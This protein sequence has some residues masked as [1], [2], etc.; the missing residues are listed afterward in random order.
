MMYPLVRDLAAR[1]APIRVPVTVACR[2]LGF[3]KQGYY[4]WLSNPV[5]NRD[6]DEAHLINAAYD[7][8]AED[9][10]F[11]YRL[12]SDELAEQ[13]F[14]ASERRVWRLCSQQRLWSVFSK[15]KG[16]TRK[17]GPPVHDDLVKRVFIADGPN[18]LWL[19]DITEHKTAEGKLYLC[20]IKDVFANKIVG[21]SID[22]RMKARLAVD[23]LEMA[24]AHRGQPTGVVVH[25]DYAEDDVKPRN[26]AHASGSLGTA[27]VL[28]A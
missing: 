5:S 7:A 14:T 19:T 8:H 27:L 24:V 6:W 4:R 3:S 1:S 21:Y 12:I 16:K 26:R 15:K 9:P 18:K 23:A 13:G 25:S 28:S 2:V 17:P 11:G 22:S 20:A 10:A